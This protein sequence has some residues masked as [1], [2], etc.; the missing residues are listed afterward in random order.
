MQST[1]YSCEILINLEISPKFSKEAQ[2]STCMKINIVAAELHVAWKTD[3]R[4]DVQTDR[5]TE[6]TKLL[7]ALRNFANVPRSTNHKTQ[8]ISYVS[9]TKISLL[10]LFT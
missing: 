1:L 7:V 6:I 3:G 4:P 2:I 5:Q 9:I 8:E 10:I